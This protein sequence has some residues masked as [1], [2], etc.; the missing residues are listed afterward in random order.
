M[1]NTTIMKKVIAIALAAILVLGT[2]ITLKIYGSNDSTTSSEVESTKNISSEN[3]GDYEAI[4]EKDNVIDINVEIA[5]E[6]LESIL[7]DPMAEEYKSA[8]V[9][10]DG[11]TLDNV[12]FR[13][14]GNLTLKSVANSDSE[15][16][17]FR[18]KLDK[19]V[20]GQDL[21]GLDEFVVNNMYSD[22][23]YMREYL[24]YEA[25]RETGED[26]PL[27]TFANVYVNGELYGFYLMVEAI[28]DSFLERSFGDD[29]GNL[30]KAEKGST[31]QYA[32]GSEYDSLELKSGKDETKTNL[33]NFM[34]TLNEVSEGEKG[35]IESVL[36]VDSALRYIAAN[37]VLGNY[38]S[39]SGNM[40][41][42]YYLYEQDGKFTV[43]PWDYNMSMGGF[44][45]GDQTT[46]PIDEPVFGVNIE[47]LPLIDNLLQ[48]E[49]YKDT[50]YKYINELL[51]YLERFEGRVTELADII[52]PYIEADPSKFYTMEQFEANI[53][54]SEDNTDVI[55]NAS[56]NINSKPE[57]EALPQE[58]DKTSSTSHDMNRNSPDGLQEQSP[59]DMPRDFEDGDRPQPPYEGM[60]D[61]MKGRPGGG[62]GMMGNSTSIINFIRDRAENIKQQLAGELPTTG[63]TT[64]KNM[65]RN[66]R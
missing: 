65:G 64:I 66:D 5:E 23:S 6:D 16:Y 44:G 60:G 3:L 56:E 61:N 14:K 11:V 51:D 12:G 37:T 28:D 53:T 19:Y 35:D 21:L 49:E 25:L 46:I 32:E 17:S 26:V 22:P 52:E 58:V 50:Y 42:N 24:S 59:Q 2:I 18:I 1:N 34:K 57:N 20:D 36:D 48:I 38:D 33:Q 43:I 54:Y 8:T 63:N 7:D 29:S 41:Q 47:S 30:Y 10:V 4:F 62:M 9:T 39:Y 45:G 13:T 15:R 55:S 27:T 31:L 40:A